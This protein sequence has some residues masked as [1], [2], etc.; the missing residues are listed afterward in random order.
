[1]APL[2]PRTPPTNMPLT[3]TREAEELSPVKELLLLE[4]RMASMGRPASPESKFFDA[5]FNLTNAQ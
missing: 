5:I 2:I 1:M 4:R 3:L